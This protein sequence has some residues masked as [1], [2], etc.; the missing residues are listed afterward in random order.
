[1]KPV[2]GFDYDTKLKMP[3]FVLSAPPKA[4]HQQEETPTESF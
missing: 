4:K 3:S 2:P 1:M